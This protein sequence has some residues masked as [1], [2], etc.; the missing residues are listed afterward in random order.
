MRGHD[1]LAEDA[2]QAELVQA[3]SELIV[4]GEVIGDGLEAATALQIGS[5]KSQRGAH[6]EFVYSHQTSYQGRR[7]EVGRDAESLEARRERR[8]LGTVEA[9]D[10]ADPRIRQRRGHALQ[11]V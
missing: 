8:A 9:R 11:V 4:V 7:R 5:P 1:H 2:L 10:Q 6:G 3:A